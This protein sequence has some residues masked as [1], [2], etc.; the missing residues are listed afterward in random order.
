MTRRH[1]FDAVRRMLGRGFTTAEVQELDRAIDAAIAGVV[2]PVE[3]WISLAAPL[4]EQFEGLAKLIPGDKVEAYPDPG[5]GGEPWTIGIGSTTDENGAP[6][7]PGDVW[8]VARARA[9]FQAHLAEFG[10]E[11]DRLIAGKP[12]TALQKAAMTSLAY[13]IGI[14]ALSRS[15]VLRRHRAGD[16]PAAADAFALW[17]KAGGRVM[18]GLTRRR[19]AEADLYRKG[20]R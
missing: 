20:S 10:Q 18:P 1:I 7:R 5:S 17:N 12:T 3:D 13:N 8:S 6:V 11:V 4:V 15:T 14:G 19:K 2:A 9:R 16:Y